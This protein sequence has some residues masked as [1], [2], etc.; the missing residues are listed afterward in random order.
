[1]GGIGARVLYPLSTQT[2]R[3]A[4]EMKLDGV[5]VVVMVHKEHAYT[6]NF[7][8]LCLFSSLPRAQ[9]VNQVFFNGCWY[10]SAIVFCFVCLFLFSLYCFSLFAKLVL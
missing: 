4:K 2:N 8:T 7:L 5:M 6:S 1:M 10:Q 3:N 9:K